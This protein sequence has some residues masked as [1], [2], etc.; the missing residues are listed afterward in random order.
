MIY[1]VHGDDIAKSRALITNQQKKL[2]VEKRTELILGDVTPQQ[3]LE[4]TRTGDLFGNAP[5]VVVDASKASKSVLEE[6]SEVLPQINKQSTIIIIFSKELTKTNPIL[7]KATTLDIRTSLAV[8][9]LEGNVFKF[10]DALYSKNRKH[11]YTELQ[12]LYKEDADPFYIF[13]M[14]V[15]GLRNLGMVAFESPAGFKMNPYVKTKTSEQLKNFNEQKIKQI[16][17]TLYDLDKKTKTGAIDADLALTL[18]IEKV[19]NS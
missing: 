15:Y 19:L 9:T 7:Q 6:F 3:F 1:L 8:K 17:T 2:G 12:N 5:F 13:S 18:A 4:S 11:T 16:Y 10:V 14:L